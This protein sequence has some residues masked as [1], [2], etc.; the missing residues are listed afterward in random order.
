MRCMMANSPKTFDPIGIV[1][2]WLDAC[3]ERRLLDVIELYADEA[4]IECCTGGHFRGRP[5]LFRYWTPKFEHAG[6]GAFLLHEVQPDGTRVRLD[7]C[8]YDGR[9]RK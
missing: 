3:R 6:A 4:S 2:D 7:Y 9:P 1:I 5:A 8:D